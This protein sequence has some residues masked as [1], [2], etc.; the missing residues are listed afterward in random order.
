MVASGTV[1]SWLPRCERCAISSR[2]ATPTL[3]RAFAGLSPLFGTAAEAPRMRQ[4]YRRLPETNFSQHVLALVPERLAVLKV[5][6]LRWS[7][8]GDPQRVRAALQMAGVRPR[9]VEQG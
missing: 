7:D 1:L 6:G 2:S 9:W 3:Y 4:L 5:T 8:L